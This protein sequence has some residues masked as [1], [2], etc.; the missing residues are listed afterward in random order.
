MPGALY[1]AVVSQAILN[2]TITT[3]EVDAVVDETTALEPQWR[4]LIYNDDV[5]PYLF[6]IHVL[7]TIFRLGGEIAEHITWIA[8]TTGL[9]HVVTRPKTEAETL[10]AKAHFAA[11]LEGYPLTFTLE[12]EE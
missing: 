9:A 8:H 1:S 6:V 12:P 11:R 2:P 4:V 7:E 3:P 10:V 5:T